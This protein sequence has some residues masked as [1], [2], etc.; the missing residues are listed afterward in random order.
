LE[1]NKIYCGNSL[2]ILRTFPDKV[3]QCCVTSPP[4]FGLRSYNTGHWIGG[5]RDCVHD[6]VPARNGR[7]GSGPN[8]KNTTDSYPSEFPSPSCSKCGAI[9]EDFQLGL[10][11]TPD[12]YTDHLVEVFREVK[13][14]LRDDGV[15]WLN[16]G[17][18]YA[19]SWGNAGHRPELD[20][21]PSHQREKNCDY[22]PRGGWDDRRD[23]PASS[24]KLPNIKAKDLIGIPWKLAFALRDDGWWLR[25]DI[26][27]AKGVSGQKELT[28]QIH[29]AGIEIGIEENKIEALIE[30][31]GLYVGNSMPESVV[32]RP[33]KSH[34]Y[35]F[36]LTK[37]KK[38]FYD[39]DA[40]RED[41]VTKDNKGR[42]ES[43][44]SG[45]TS[46]MRGG[47]HQVKNGSF[48]GLPL[49]PLG[50]NLRSVW[51]LVTKPFKSAHF[52]VFPEELILNPIKSSTSEKGCC[53]A[54]NAPYKRILLKKS[55]VIR[56]TD[57]VALM[58]EFGR[59]QS[60]GTMLSPTESKTVGWQQT[61]S[62][63]LDCAWGDP[64][65][66]LVLDP[67]MGSGTVGVVS[68]KLGRNFV[69]IDLNKSYVDM[70]NE[71]ISKVMI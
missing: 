38:Y 24:Y 31:L 15:F 62:C 45:S 41:L 64:E 51:T 7:G 54:C 32:D 18:S 30:S 2:N 34:E 1:R 36:M 28:S 65:P 67:F 68:K 58:G 70:A 59:T 12:E 61:C 53:P 33:S 52:A 5:S 44:P 40:V 21:S 14:T 56:K 11:S 10:E 17:D 16:L 42:R 20:D 50:R 63:I 27:W 57:R 25:S 46:S 60:S 6:T 29:N 23:R 9:Y 3:F 8:A 13:R 35:L 47:V 39:N 55:M 66:C 37:S 26:I 4:F 19:G 49:N 48:A 71:R 69:G 22:L 43:Y